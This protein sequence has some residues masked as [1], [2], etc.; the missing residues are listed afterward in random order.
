M[1]YKHELENQIVADHDAGRFK[2]LT[3][4]DRSNTGVA[5]LNSARDID[6]CQ[7]SYASPYPYV[8]PPVILPVYV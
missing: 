7:C 6:E 3:F 2:D 4:F 8:A 5:G 1:W